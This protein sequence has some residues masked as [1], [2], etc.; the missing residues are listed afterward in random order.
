[1]RG[2]IITILAIGITISAAFFVFHRKELSE[3]NSNKATIESVL[4]KIIPLSKIDIEGSELPK[5]A[6]ESRIDVIQS[7]IVKALSTGTVPV[8]IS[9]VPKILTDSIQA[10]DQ[11]LAE[12]LLII[13]PKERFVLIEKINNFKYSFDAA[14]KVRGGSLEFVIISTSRYIAAWSPFYYYI[15]GDA[16]SVL[17][18]IIKILERNRIEMFADFVN[19]NPRDAGNL[20]AYDIEYYIEDIRKSAARRNSDFITSSL[21]GYNRYRKNFDS[22]AKSHREFLFGFAERAYI[23]FDDLYRMH[24]EV[25][26]AYLEKTRKEVEDMRVELRGLHKRALMDFAKFDSIAARSALTKTISV[27][28]SE[29]STYLDLREEIRDIIK[30][31]HE[32]YKAIR[33]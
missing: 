21:E 20:A 29:L 32:F 27:I 14:L 30:S 17:G 6:D 4:S 11:Y 15:H 9:T 3:I 26:N 10:A 24:E 18:P 16:K 23:L 2:I 1:M 28:E 25:D 13:D 22:I 31:D 19:Y 8:D 7:P 33:L 12:A 5:I